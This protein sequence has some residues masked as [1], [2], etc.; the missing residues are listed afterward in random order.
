M[1]P[2]DNK[3]KIVPSK[4]RDPA[5]DIP[6]MLEDRAVKAGAK[7][8]GVNNRDLRTLEVDIE[9]SFR[10]RPSIPPDVAAVK[11]TEET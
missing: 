6:N 2:S 10:L 4:E 9:T 5:K 8:V 11:T 1:I 3:L 7:I